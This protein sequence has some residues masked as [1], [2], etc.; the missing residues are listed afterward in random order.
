MK[1]KT[2]PEET[3]MCT[4]IKGS[5]RTEYEGTC[6]GRTS[7][8]KDSVSDIVMCDLIGISS[9]I[10]KN[11]FGLRTS[12]SRAP[13]GGLPEFHVEVNRMDSFQSH[14]DYSTKAFLRLPKRSSKKGKEQQMLGSIFK[15]TQK[16]F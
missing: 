12:S 13:R 15:T 8:G 3:H 16:M 2:A 1:D 10:T 4:H 14:H 6:V 11:S 7:Q 5:C 9:R